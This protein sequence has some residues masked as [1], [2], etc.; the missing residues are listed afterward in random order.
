MLILTRK[1]GESIIIGSDIKVTVVSVRGRQVH[2]GIDAPRETSV[3]REEI[4]EKI[5]EAN[6]MAAKSSSLQGLRHIIKVMKR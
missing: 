2:L 3:Y 1:S 4:F 5:K 6:L